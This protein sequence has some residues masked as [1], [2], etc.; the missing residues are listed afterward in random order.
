[1][2]R[3]GQQV[4]LIPVCILFYAIR[5]I[6]DDAPTTANNFYMAYTG[7]TPLTIV[8]IRWEKNKGCSSGF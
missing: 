5:P 8:H 4:N 7:V 3:K 2:I 1:M 6:G